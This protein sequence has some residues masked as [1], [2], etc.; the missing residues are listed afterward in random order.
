MRS[1]TKML[2]IFFFLFLLLRG[3]TGINCYS[4]HSGPNSAGGVERCDADSVC[5]SA[6]IIF[7]EEGILRK[8]MSRQCV[9]R[10]PDRQGKEWPWCTEEW[11]GGD[12]GGME[13]L[14][15]FCNSDF[16]NDNN[17]LRGRFSEWTATTMAR[18][19]AGPTHVL[20]I[21]VSVATTGVVIFFIVLILSHVPWSAMLG[22][23]KPV[24]EVDHSCNIN[25]DQE[26]DTSDEEE[27]METEPDKP[28]APD[29]G[30]EK[31]E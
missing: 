13:V 21:V 30:K 25:P 10:T 20:D 5:S 27:A 22:R 8:A 23:V 9:A 1:L 17:F 16:C 24:V 19:K 28:T 11:A 3:C 6:R 4:D 31:E 26:Y 7:R 29:S 18:L 15:C 14:T 2:S 12:E